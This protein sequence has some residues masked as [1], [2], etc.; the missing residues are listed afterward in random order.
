MSESSPH[1]PDGTSGTPVERQ[2][3]MAVFAT[4]ETPAL[5]AACGRLG[6]LPAYGFLRR[7]ESGSILVQGRAGGTGAPFHLGEMTVTRCTV[8]LESAVQGAAQEAP[9]EA[10]PQ[11]SAVGTAYI[12]GRNHRHAELA[13]LLDALMQHPHWRDPVQSAVL[14]PLAAA[15]SQARAERTTRAASTKVDFFTLARES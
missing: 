4:A 7:P 13:A 10:S 14:T 8:R 12:A 9:P 6:P 1:P 2:A 11:P 15:R 3:W 5:E